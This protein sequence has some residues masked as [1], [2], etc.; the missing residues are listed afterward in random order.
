[1]SRLTRIIG[2]SSGIV[3]VFLFTILTDNLWIFFIIVTPMIIGLIVIDRWKARDSRR[4][5]SAYPPAETKSSSDNTPEA[6]GPGEEN[7]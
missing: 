3:V 7:R 2:F 4:Q 5:L 6:N 1:M